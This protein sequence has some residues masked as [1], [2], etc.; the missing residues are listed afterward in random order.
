MTSKEA[1]EKQLEEIDAELDELSSSSSGFKL[2]REIKRLRAAIFSRESRPARSIADQF[3]SQHERAER[4]R[5][6]QR[7]RE[8]VLE[9][10]VTYESSA[11]SD[12]TA[13]K[14]IRDQ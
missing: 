14:R 8:E 11:D 6:L 9:E 3:S 12:E 2:S 4:I 5:T 10:L 7:E 1:L 13:A